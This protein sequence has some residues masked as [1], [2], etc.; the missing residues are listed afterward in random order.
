MVSN[1]VLTKDLVLVPE[2]G[3]S[4]PPINSDFLG[5]DSLL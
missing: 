1:L 5:S 3:S 2:P 4:Q